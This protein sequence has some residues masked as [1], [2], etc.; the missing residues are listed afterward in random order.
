VI[1]VNKKGNY[2]VSWKKMP[3]EDKILLVMEKLCYFLTAGAL[4]ALIFVINRG[5][6]IAI[7]LLIIGMIGLTACGLSARSS[8]ELF[9]NVPKFNFKLNNKRVNKVLKLN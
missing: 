3:I 8:R 7:G 5:S 2:I 1:L 9:I 4:L 6:I